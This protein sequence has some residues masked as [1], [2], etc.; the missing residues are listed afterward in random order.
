MFE[1]TAERVLAKTGGSLLNNACSTKTGGVNNKHMARALGV[2]R[3][4]R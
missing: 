3:E 4:K 2:I 1:E